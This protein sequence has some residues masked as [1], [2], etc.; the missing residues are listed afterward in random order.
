[1]IGDEIYK[2]AKELWPINR[3]I[4]GEGVRETLERIKVHL[5]K[6]EIKSV[7]SGTPVFD[8]KIPREWSVNEAYIVSPSGEKMCDFNVNNL[9]LLGYSVPFEGV[10]D[11]CELR[12]HLYTL[13]EQPDAI[14]YIT[15]YYKE[16]WGFCMSQE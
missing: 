15:S 10:I 9:H 7:P 16:R 11:L 14:P 4:T 3:S 5:P 13:P 1:M 2:F 8:W 6:L 12:E